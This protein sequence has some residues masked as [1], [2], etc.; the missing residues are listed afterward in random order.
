MLCPKCGAGL[1]GAWNVSVDAL[2]YFRH[3]QRSP[4]SEAQRA[5]R[6]SLAV[7]NE[8]ETLLQKYLTYLLERGLISPIHST[9]Q[10][11]ERDPIP[12]SFFS[13]LRAQPIM[14]VCM[15]HSTSQPSFLQTNAWKA[16]Q[17]SL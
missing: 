6:P 11:V 4:Y 15:T 1:P 5:R 12:P 17:R 8:L 7:Q 3:F 13:C 9:D 14:K 2:K 10:E 16:R